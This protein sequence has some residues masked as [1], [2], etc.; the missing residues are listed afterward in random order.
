MGTIGSPAIKALLHMGEAVPFVGPV[1][2]VLFSLKQYVDDYH[3]A[4]EECQRLS[5]NPIEC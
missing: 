5:V 3:D 1:C 4:G 2:Q